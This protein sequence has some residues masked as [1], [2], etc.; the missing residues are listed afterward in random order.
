MFYFQQKL[1]YHVKT[2]SSDFQKTPKPKVSRKQRI[3]KGIS[4]TNYA[5]ELSRC[6]GLVCPLIDDKMTINDSRSLKNKFNKEKD[7]EKC[8]ESVKSSSISSKLPYHITKTL[9]FNEL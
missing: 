8:D 1:N 3:D 4:K 2:H 5:L 6:N 7:F 9:L